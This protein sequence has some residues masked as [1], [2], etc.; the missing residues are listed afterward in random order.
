MKPVRLLSRKLKGIE[1]E[2]VTFYRT[3]GEKV[4]LNP[5]MTDVFAYLKIY[6]A[7]TQEQLKEL[8]KLSS[9]TISSTLQVFL[10]TSIVS[11]TMIPGTHTNIY[12]IDHERADF[13][14]TPSTQIL[15][16]LERLDSYL[17]EKQQ[18]LDKM[19]RDHPV[20]VQFLLLRLNS[21]RNYIE[22]QRRQIAGTSKHSFL[23]EDTSSVVTLDE[24]VDYPFDTNEIERTVMSVIKYFRHDSN[25]NRMLGIFFTHR[26][27][28]QQVLID[29]SGF[30]RSTVSRFLKQILDTEYIQALP[31]EYRSPVV[32]CQ[33][34]ISLSILSL[35]LNTDSYIYSKVPRFKEMLASIQSDQQST[36]N[37]EDAAFLVSMIQELVNR[38]EAFRKGT[39]PFRQAFQELVE[40]LGV[41]T[42]EG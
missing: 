1:Q 40:F 8:T 11:R 41:G 17:V 22:V 19:K 16:D 15:D 31:R 35:I 3:V 10:Q 39:S 36:R 24:I 29:K 4:H 9:G 13:V 42:K 37:D 6:G 34:F 23:P 33:E 14:Y 38:I 25:K 30:S 26:S 18:S 20:E 21:L 7:L 32:Y 27:L 2:I 28:T 12:R 5:R